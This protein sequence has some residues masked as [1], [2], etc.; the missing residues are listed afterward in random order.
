MLQG[1][2]RPGAGTG[3]LRTR[4][5]KR[6]HRQPALEGRGRRRQPLVVAR[7]RVQLGVRGWLAQGG[8]RK[9]AS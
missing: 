3:V 2:C 5:H 1:G 7:G 4:P 9:L 6:A 8:G